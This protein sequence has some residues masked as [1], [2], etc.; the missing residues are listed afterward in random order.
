MSSCGRATACVRACANFGCTL[1]TTA[2]GVPCAP[3]PPE[4]GG[5]RG[6][7]GAPAASLDGLL[8]LVCVAVVPIALLVVVVSVLRAVVVVATTT[9]APAPAPTPMPTVLQRHGPE[10]LHVHLAL[11]RHGAALARA[12]LLAPVQ[13]LARDAV[14]EGLGLVVRLACGR[15][16]LG[17]LR[18]GFLALL[19][20]LGCRRL[21]GFLQLLHQTVLVEARIGLLKVK[22]L[23]HAGV[24]LRLRLRLRLRHV[25]L[26]PVLL[27]DVGPHVPMCAWVG[28]E[29]MCE[30][31][32]VWRV[33][34][35]SVRVCDGVSVSGVSV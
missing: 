30:R 33:S 35:W 12:A 17:L 21:L 15:V 6:S 13:R 7:A 32:S 5:M 19:G 16:E 10:R 4:D 8:E 27:V 31:V 34:V 28:G 14:E 22:V 3:A 23:H 11:L 20:T 29:W 18:H 25:L 1:A 9:P 2:A 26:P 24:H